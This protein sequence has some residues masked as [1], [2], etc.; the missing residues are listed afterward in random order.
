MKP[1]FGVKK[2]LIPAV[3]CLCF[4]IGCSPGNNGNEDNREVNAVINIIS[5]NHQSGHSDTALSEPVGV[6]VTDMNREPL[7]GVNLTLSV[8]EG[9][10]RIVNGATFTT[11]STGRIVIQWI[12][13]SGYNGI[14]VTSSSRK[15]FAAPAYICATGENASGIHIT[16]TISSFRHIAGVLYEITFYGQYLSNTVAGRY[17]SH[18]TENRYHC[19]LFSV[20]GDRRNYYMG[21]SFDNPAGWERLTLLTRVNPADGYASIAPVRMGDVGLYK[22]IDFNTLRFGEKT[23]L[24]QTI[25][26]P[27]DGINQHGLTVGLANVT[28]QPYIPDPL[29][30]TISCTTLVRKILD[31]A[32]TVDEAAAIALAHN[33]RRFGSD[34]LDIHAMVADASGRSIILEPA[35]GEMKVIPGSGPFQVMTNSPV[36][37]VSIEE[38]INQC[39]RF[40]TIYQRLNSLNGLLDHFGIMGLLQQVGNRWT[41]WSANY[42]I[43]AKSAT[44]AIDFNFTTLY[45]FN[46][47]PLPALFENF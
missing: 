41:E 35:D 32:R 42:G 27:P 2:S 11:N 36:Y 28:N 46:M 22:G 29:K 30:P 14:E 1:L 3:I 38:Q 34:F 16:R 4:L 40:S 21:R 19:S 12:I 45:D 39:P 24:I 5:G 13:G 15:Y 7:S 17:D 47:F 33:I 25:A 43:S 20:F 9:E 26:H 37:N 18:S 6:Q 23:R 10:G 31:Q 44:L 8:V